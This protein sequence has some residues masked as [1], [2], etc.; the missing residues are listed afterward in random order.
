MFVSE[1]LPD[2][3]Y[4][5]PLSLAIDNEDVG[6]MELLLSHGADPFFDLGTESPMS[7]AAVRDSLNASFVLVQRWWTRGCVAGKRKRED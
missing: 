6:V 2:T 5:L 4:D 1:F 7:H 3:L